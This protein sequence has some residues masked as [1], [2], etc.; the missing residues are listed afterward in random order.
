MKLERGIYFLC[1]VKHFFTII[2]TIGK[3]K[4]IYSFKN[5]YKAYHIFFS[6]QKHNLKKNGKKQE[7]NLK[8]RLIC[9]SLGGLPLRKTAWVNA[10]GQ[11]SY[12]FQRAAWWRCVEGQAVQDPKSPQSLPPRQCY[13]CYIFN[14]RILIKISFESILL[15]KNKKVGKI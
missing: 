3:I 8:V 6:F 5:Q 12:R 14:M 2:T 15:L 13:S 11:S 9:L 7:Q 4:S 1:I 10:L